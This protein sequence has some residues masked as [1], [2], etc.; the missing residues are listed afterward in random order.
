MV[1]GQGKTAEEVV[2]IMGALA[3]DHGRVLATRLDD[4]QRALLRE[5]YERASTST[6]A[7]A[8]R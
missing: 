1:Y 3:E 6:R 2:E 5:S 4:S 7:R 8:P